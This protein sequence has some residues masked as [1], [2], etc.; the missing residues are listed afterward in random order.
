[1]LVVLVSTVLLSVSPEFSKHIRKIM[2]CS[3]NTLAEVQPVQDFVNLWDI[4]FAPADFET[5]GTHGFCKVQSSF[6]RTDCTRRF[7]ILMHAL[8]S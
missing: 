6:Y 7:K 5:I 3:G 2:Y 4:T 1:M 8:K